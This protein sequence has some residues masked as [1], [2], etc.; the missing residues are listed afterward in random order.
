MPDGPHL[1][2]V[3]G[4]AGNDEDRE[5][6]EH[7]IELQVGT[8]ADEIQECERDREVGQ[9]DQRIRDNVESENAGLPQIAHAMRHETVCG[10]EA[11]DLLHLGALRPGN[12]EPGVSDD[13]SS[14]FAPHWTYTVAPQQTARDIGKRAL[15]RMRAGSVATSG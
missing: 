15:R 4:P 6:D 14:F 13:S 2:Q 7:P 1:H 8:L 11:L 10:E 9:C 12:D 3:R 5:T